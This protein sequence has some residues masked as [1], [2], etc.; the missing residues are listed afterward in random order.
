MKNKEKRIFLLSILAS[1]FLVLLTYLLNPILS[2]VSLLADKGPSW[3][4]WKLPTRDNLTMIIVWL[5]FFVHLLGNYFL[6]RKRLLKKEKYFIKE[7]LYL[8]FFNLIFIILH[9]IQTMFFYDGLA[10]D[11]P[12]FTS[13]YSVILILVTLILMQINQRGF[14]FSYKIKVPPK[15]M[16]LLYS[17]HGF[18]F[19]F[20][21]VY[22]FWFHPVVFTIGHAIGFLYIFLLFIQIIFIKTKVHYNKYW[23][24]SLEVLVAFH[25]ASVAFFVQK[26][27]IWP[28]FLFGFLF[29]FIATQIYSLDI[30][31][32][33]RII[34]QAIYFIIVFIFYLNFNIK[35]IH[36]ILW[37]PTI[38]YLHVII[39]LIILKLIY[40]K[41]PRH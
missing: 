9:F 4:Y 30:Q 33:T 11:V 18:I 14:I 23:I 38:E 17:I 13:Q 15:A 12:I 8:L 10:Q 39:L 2:D 26:S 32:Q 31:K 34:I 1:F 5:L 19:T 40:K 7:N 35:L 36:Q 22:T 24:L 20:A 41:K 21:I 28:M 3:Y 16:K 25:G 27:S 29:I 37:I 6:I